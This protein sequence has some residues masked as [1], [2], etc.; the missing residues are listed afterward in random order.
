MYLFQMAS[1]M[2]LPPSSWTAS[3]EG[4]ALAGVD[5]VAEAFVGRAVVVGGG[6]GGAEPALVDAAAVEAEGVEIVRVELE[7]LAGLE[8]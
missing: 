3:V 4:E 5:D 7:A 6:R 8:E 2:I 1:P